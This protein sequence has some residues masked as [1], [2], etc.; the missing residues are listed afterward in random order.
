M[1]DGL[2]KQFKIKH[3][4]SAIYRS[5]M[6]VAV[7]AAYK[8]LKKIVRKMTEKHRDWH[9]KLSYALMAYRT[10]IRT[11]IEAMPYS[12][13]YGMEVVLPAEIEIPSLHILMEAQ[14]EEAEW[15]KQRHEQLSLIDERRL[16]AICHGQCY[17]RRM[18]HAYNKKV[19]PRLFK[20][21][22]QF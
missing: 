21:E 2:C 3:R 9:E 12:L 16:N 10:A 6:N 15:I 1:V 22:I 19:R 4:N 14:L 13:M 7:E 17:Q 18:A 5:Q 20:E 11:S 8:N